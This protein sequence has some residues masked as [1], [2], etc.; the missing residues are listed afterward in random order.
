M[1]KMSAGFGQARAVLLARWA[2]Y[3]DI[4]FG[5]VVVGKMDGALAVDDAVIL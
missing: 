1:S 3:E 5:F 4:G 2:Q